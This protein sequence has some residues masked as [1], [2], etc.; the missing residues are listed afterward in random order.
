MEKKRALITDMEM[1]KIYDLLDGIELDIEKIE[2]SETKAKCQ[3][4]LTKIEALFE[5]YV[6]RL[7]QMKNM[8]TL[9]LT[10][11]GIPMLLSGDEFANTQWGNNNAYCQGRQITVAAAG[12]NLGNHISRNTDVVLFCFEFRI[13]NI[14]T[15]VL[16]EGCCVICCL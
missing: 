14:V 3:E 16:F 5:T 7:R 11:R 15:G 12:I 13:R 6:L 10:S 9:L 1:K 8:L 4:E 2:D